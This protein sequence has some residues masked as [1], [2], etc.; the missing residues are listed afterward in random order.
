MVTRCS[1]LSFVGRQLISWNSLIHIWCLKLIFKQKQI[2]LFWVTCIF[3]LIFLLTKGTKKN[4]H[5][6]SVVKLRSYTA[7]Y[8]N[9]GFRNSFCLHKDC[10]FSLILLR[11]FMSMDSSLKLASRY[12]AKVF[13][14]IK[15]CYFIV[16]VRYVKPLRYFSLLKRMH[17]VLSSLK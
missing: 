16:L 1:T 6:Q 4:T 5:S 11:D 8:A 2:H 9:F 13:Y 15:L 10:N 17:L 3:F 12:T 14:Y 7:A